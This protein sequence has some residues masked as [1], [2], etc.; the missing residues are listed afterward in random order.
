MTRRQKKKK[1]KPINNEG[2]R[3]LQKRSGCIGREYC[4]ITWFYQGIL[5]CKLA[6]VKSF[7]S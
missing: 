1:K 2:N 3:L 5:Q 6:T 4:Q 7:Q